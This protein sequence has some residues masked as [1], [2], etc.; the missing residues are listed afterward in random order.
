MAQSAGGAWLHDDL[1][2]G[3]P[4]GDLADVR[5]RGELRAGDLGEVDHERTA[6]GR[7][8]PC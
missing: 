1:E 5:F 2:V 6:A 4:E 7:D 3:V 8:Q